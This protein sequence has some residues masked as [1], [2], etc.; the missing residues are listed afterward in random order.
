[1]AFRK[2]AMQYHP[3]VCSARRAEPASKDEA[4]EM[5]QRFARLHEAAAILSDPARRAAHDGARS[6]TADGEVIAAWQRES[7]AAAAWP[8]GGGGGEGQG[9][10]R[11]DD[12]E[13][14]YERLVGWVYRNEPLL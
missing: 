7:E 12:W 8:G 10:R 4:A 9:R 1:M 14:E 6:R 2:L 13:A 11:R 3:D 5:N